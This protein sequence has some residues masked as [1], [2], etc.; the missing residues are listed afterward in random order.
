MS[1]AIRTYVADETIWA[2]YL[3]ISRT[4]DRLGVDKQGQLCKFQLLAMGVDESRIVVFDENNTSATKGADKRPEY[5]RMLAEAKAGRIGGVMVFVQDRFTRDIDELRSLFKLGIRLATSSTGEVD[6]TDPDQKASSQIA[7]INAER[8]VELISKRV[9]SNSAMRASLGMAHGQAPFGWRREVELRNGRVVRSWDELDEA[10]AGLLRHAAAQVLKGISLRS[11]AAELNAGEVKPRARTL[12]GGKYKDSP[13]ESR[14]VWSSQQ[15]RTLLLRESNAGLRR[16]RGE[17]LDG[18]VGEWPPIFDEVTYRR[19][20]LLFADPSRRASDKGSAP[21]WLLSGI[22]TC[23]V[24]P[25]GGRFLVHTGG[26]TRNARP[27]YV[28]VGALGGKGCMQRHYVDD[29]DNEIARL[30]AERLADPAF[31]EVDPDAQLKIDELRAKI[32]E[33][34]ERMAEA[35]KLAATKAIKLAQLVEINAE[36][37][38]TIERLG[39][40]IDELEPQTLDLGIEPGSFALLDVVEKRAVVRQLFASIVFV[41]STVH[42]RATELRRAS[43][44]DEIR[45]EFKGRAA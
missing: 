16:H 44:A 33:E 4:D 35:G 30:V 24:C 23:D 34:R 31:A 32:D 8:E 13:R 43:V 45:V 3:R 11:V 12:K 40:E 42:G 9:K 22:A 29:V 10:E 36:A 28:C 2:I 14:R 39:R 18:V 15:L 1:Q 38:A 19:L 41:P 6:W 21:A 26:T 37:E 20:R 25:D 7:T 27:A 5:L 17:V